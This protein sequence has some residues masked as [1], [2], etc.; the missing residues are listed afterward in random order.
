MATQSAF[1][2]YVFEQAALGERLTRKRMFGEFAIYLDGKT[3]AFACD[4]SLLVKAA[5]ATETLTAHLPRRAPYPGAKLYPVA[6]ELLDDG[7]RLRELLLATGHALP[8][9]KPKRTQRKSSKPPAGNRSS[10]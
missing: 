7:E 9:P 10:P 5:D 8:A 2:A 1:V 4:D 6:D 3:V